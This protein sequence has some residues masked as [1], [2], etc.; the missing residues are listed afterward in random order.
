MGLLDMA[1]GTASEAKS[2]E[3]EEL[4]EPILVDGEVVTHAYVLGTRDLFLITSKRM[5][6]VDKTGFSGKK[7]HII[8][9]PW[10]TII[11]WAMATSG[12]LDFDTELVFVVSQ[13]MG[14]IVV[15]F[16][17]KVDLKPI[18]KTISEHVLLR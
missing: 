7:M 3:V 18:V 6:R 10:H 12:S 4:I 8:S 14:P 9:H 16:P 11:S 13:H 17:K 5:I 2:K 15:H 1:L